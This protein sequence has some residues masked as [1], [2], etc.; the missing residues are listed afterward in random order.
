MRNGEEKPTRLEA[1][2]AMESVPEA[3]LA[4]ALIVN[5]ACMVP[6]PCRAVPCR[7]EPKRMRMDVDLSAAVCFCFSG[8][9]RSREPVEGQR[10]KG[11]PSL[12]RRVREDADWS[13]LI[14]L[15]HR[16]AYCL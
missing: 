16:G 10:V 5:L 4:L 1:L 8:N 12:P 3:L 11:S 9:F 15:G 13:L 14:A 7:A 6:V 2:L